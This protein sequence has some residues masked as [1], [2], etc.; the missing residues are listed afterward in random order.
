MIWVGSDLMAVAGGVEK[1]MLELRDWGM[2]TGISPAMS[3]KMDATIF[4]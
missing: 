3:G 4:I 1:T 2:K